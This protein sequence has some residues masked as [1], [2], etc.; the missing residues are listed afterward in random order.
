MSL[1]DTTLKLVTNLD[2]EAIEDRLAEIRDSAQAK[3]L[4]SSPTLFRG[5]EGLPRAQLESQVRNALAGS[6]T[7]PSTRGCA[8]AS[9]SSSSTFPTCK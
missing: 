9:R 8:T 6:P 7:S 1:N 2:R 3:G 5:A 4:T